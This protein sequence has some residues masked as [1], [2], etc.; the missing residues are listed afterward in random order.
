MSRRN[1][2]RAIA[3]AAAAA[4]SLASAHAMGPA[5]PGDAVGTWAPVGACQSEPRV[6]V[7]ADAVTL[8]WHGKVERQGSL[9]VD[10]TCFSGAGRDSISYCVSPTVAGRYPYSLVFNAGEKT[11]V[12]RFDIMAGDRNTL[13][14]SGSLW[15]KCH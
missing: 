1:I 7:A 3:I 14:K 5:V 15:T 2:V 8:H 9:A 12:V 6:D 13:P 11:G 4:G 10:L